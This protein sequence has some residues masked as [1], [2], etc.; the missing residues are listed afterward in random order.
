M[1]NS[2]FVCFRRSEPQG[3]QFVPTLWK[4]PDQACRTGVPGVKNRGLKTPQTLV[5]RDP[6][7]RKPVLPE[8]GLGEIRFLFSTKRK[9]TSK[10]LCTTFGV[11]FIL[12]QQSIH[13]LHLSDPGRKC[14][15]LE[16]LLLLFGDV[17]RG[18]EAGVDLAFSDGAEIADLLLHRSAG[19]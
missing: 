12:Q 17:S 7:H 3:G 2:S 8:Q 19:S 10:Q 11:H 15:L 4:V 18:G 5:S 16:K 9:C 6:V 14:S 1:H 13:I